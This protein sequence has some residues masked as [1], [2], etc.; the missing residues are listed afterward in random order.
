MIVGG[1]GIQIARSINWTVSTTY[2]WYHFWRKD[3]HV[4]GAVYRTLNHWNHLNTLYWYLSFA[5]FLPHQRAM[6]ALVQIC[7][8]IIFYL[9]T[10][11]DT[12]IIHVIIQLTIETFGK[13]APEF[14]I[15]ELRWVCIFM[16]VQP[17]IHLTA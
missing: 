14:N 3:V 8:H 7:I 5:I 2:L 4:T 17:R 10:K 9:I 12:T 16:K 11:T 6:I 13:S 1:E 15:S